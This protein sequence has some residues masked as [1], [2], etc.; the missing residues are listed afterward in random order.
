MMSKHVTEVTG[1]PFNINEE[2]HFK[3]KT[4]TNQNRE[5]ENLFLLQTSRDSK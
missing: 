1:P 3:K 2:I 4:T 5:Y